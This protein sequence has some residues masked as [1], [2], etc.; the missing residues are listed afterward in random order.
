[1]TTNHT[2][3]VG[4]CPCG[5]PLWHAYQEPEPERPRR[6]HLL[7]SDCRFSWGVPDE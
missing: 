3:N 4:T 5:G 1:M 2:H 7:C 6:H